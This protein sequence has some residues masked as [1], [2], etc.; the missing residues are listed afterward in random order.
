MAPGLLHADPYENNSYSS[1]S[2]S[3][4]SIGQHGDHGLRGDGVIPIAVVGLSLKFPQD[5]T[6]SES[7]WNV[8]LEKRCA[9]T[10]M[11]KDRFNIDAFYGKDKT[12]KDTVCAPRL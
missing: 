5:A 4:S 9:S 8:L 2:S 12:R 11:P 3:R 1:I 10:E 7:F 6:S